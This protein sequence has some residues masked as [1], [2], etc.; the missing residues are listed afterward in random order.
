MGDNLACSPSECG[1]LSHLYTHSPSS[2]APLRIEVLVDAPELIRPF[3]DVLRDI[4]RSDFANLVLVIY[5]ADERRVRP[6]KRRLPERI[7]AALL[8]SKTRA[9]LLWK[10]YSR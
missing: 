8:D 2:R 3:A 10:V 7:R 1:M 6:V 4:A 9:A 5:N